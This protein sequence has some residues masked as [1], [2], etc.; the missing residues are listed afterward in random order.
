M[1]K[2]ALIIGA[3][4]SG[5]ACALRL[6]ASGYNVVV[7]E[8]NKD[9]GGKIYEKKIGGYR[10]N[11]GPSL[12][13][14][15]ELIDDL[16][17]DS[18]IKARMEFKQLDIICKYF[19]SDGTKIN[20]YKNP[21][22]FAEEVE[23]KTGE[24]KDN[25]LEFLKKCEYLFNLTQET[26]IFNPFRT[27]K[28]ILSWHALRVA[29]NFYSLNAFKSM[30]E[31]NRKWFSDKRVEQL[32]NRYATYNGSNPYKAPATLN[33]IAHLEHN[34]GAY[35]PEKGM[36]GLIQF[37]YESAVKKG[38]KFNFNSQVEK[39]ILENN[40]VKGVKVN[41]ETFKS[42]IVVSD[43]DIFLLYSKLLGEN[44]IPK[45]ILKQELSSSA[46]IFFWGIKNKFPDLEVHNILFSRDYKTEFDNIFK[47][48]LIYDDPTVYIHISSKFISTDAPEG[49]EN[50]FV[51]INVPNNTGQDWDKL[52]NEARKNI[53]LK[54]N[55]TLDTDI[56]SYIEYEDYVD[57]RDIEKNSGSF[58]GALYGPSSNNKMAAFFRHPNFICRFK[59]LYFT[60]G[61]VHPGGG[62]P[63]CLASAKIVSDKICKS[64]KLVI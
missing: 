35:I 26:F 1:D 33:L 34:I 37:L 63:L 61:S 44:R 40:T 30:E 53:V 11:T 39:I 2:D 13:T 24:E 27:L 43:A 31:K 49:C 42:N 29:F 7:F 22:D 15:P 38:V 20:A 17:T 52:V 54:I 60:G 55:K 46:I 14:L 28:N 45:Y 25:V 8:K 41:G 4:L 62:I 57:P 36:Y 50:W 21:D 48:K 23:K 56:E 32:F 59:G 12:L 19:Y 3:G 10:F 51:M 47:R 5:I 6:S 58:K 9:P 16:S 64:H 18:G